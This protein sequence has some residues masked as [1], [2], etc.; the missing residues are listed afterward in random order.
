MNLMKLFSKDEQK[1]LFANSK[2]AGVQ[3]VPVAYL[4]VRK[5]GYRFL[6]TSLD[7][8]RPH[9][10]YG[11]CDYDTKVVVQHFNLEQVQQQAAA[12][13][14]ELQSGKNYVAHLPLTNYLEM[15]QE[16]GTLAG[17]TNHESKTF[18]DTFIKVYGLDR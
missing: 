11:L 13:N 4:R 14:D 1:K 2:N 5:L 6:I 17:L 15:A 7:P 8:E 16:L 9:I 3:Q 18:E 10:A 12:K